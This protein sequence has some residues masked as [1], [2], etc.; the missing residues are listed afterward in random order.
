MPNA[1]DEDEIKEDHERKIAWP[2]I[3]GSI[4][5][6]F[7]YLLDLTMPNA[8]DEDEIKEDHERKIA[9][10]SINGSILSGFFSG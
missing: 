8:E 2:S 3:N 10:P 7:F 6:G 9:W 4:L 1:E 5:S